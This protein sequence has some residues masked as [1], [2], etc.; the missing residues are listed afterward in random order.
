MIETETFWTLL[1]DS[2]HWEFELFLMLL[3]DGL[4]GA[5][6][7]P[8]IR[9]WRKHHRGEEEHEAADHALLEDVRRRVQD[10]ENGEVITILNPS[11][12]ERASI[13]QGAAVSGM[14]VADYIRDAAAKRGLELLAQA[15]HDRAAEDL[16][17][18]REFEGI[19]ADGIREWVWEGD[20]D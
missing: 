15:Y 6:V 18:A 19:L 11:P 5:L 2:A 7:Y 13:H 16:E 4:I 20:E 9:A 1:H 8:R 10:I 17:M 12:E 3:F 14:S